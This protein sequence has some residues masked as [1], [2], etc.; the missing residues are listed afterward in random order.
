MLTEETQAEIRRL[1]AVEKLSKRAIGKRLGVHRNTVT[2]ALA[3]PLLAHHAPSPRPGRPNLQGRRSTERARGALPSTVLSDPAPLI[4]RERELEVLRTHLLSE[5]MRL[6]TL[7]GAGGIGKTRLAVAT[8]RCVE[9]S[10]PDGVWFV[11]LAPLNDPT[12]IDEAIKEALKLDPVPDRSPA[13]RVAGY[14]K[15]RSLLLILDNFEHLLPAAGRVSELLA[16]SPGLKVLVTSR[17]PL[18]LRLEHRLPLT[19][20]ALPDLRATDP[21]SV[22]QAPAAAL[23]LEHARRLQPELAL[24]AADARALAELLHRLDG[25]PLAIRIAA[26][27]S[28]VLSPDAILSRL[29]SRTLLSAEDAR[30]VPGRHHTLRD[31]IEWSY[32]LLSSGERAAFRHLGVFVGGWTLAAAE[33]VVPAGDP[34]S[35]VWATLT[36]VVDKSLAQVDAV[37]T[38]ERRYRM[39]E[40]IRDYA[41]EQLR[42]YEELEAARDRHARY[43]VAVAEQ[44]EAASF[45]PQDAMWFRRAAGD[46]DNFR[47]ALRWAVEQRDGSL[48]LRLAGSLA[49]FWAW[50]GSVR[51]GLRWLGAAR[52][53]AGDTPPLIRAKALTA[54]ASLAMFLEDDP[55]GRTL[56]RDA[57]ALAETIG[58]PTLTAR[59]LGRFGALAAREGDAREARALLE[60]SVAA[61][62]E[63]EDRREAAIAVIGLGRCFL[64]LDDPEQAE[65]AFNQGVD[66]GRR[67]GSTMIMELALTELARFK[68]IRHDYVAAGALALEAL[69]VARAGESRRGITVAA[70]IAAQVSGHR[71][72]VERAARLLAA[73]DA[74]SDWGQVLSRY[75]DAA[76]E[77]ALHV[78]AREQMGDAVYPAAMAEA[79][80][81]SVEQIAGMAQACLERQTA[82][83]QDGAASR[84]L[85]SDRERAVLRLIGEGLPNKQIATALSIAERTVKTHVASAMNKLGVDNRAHAAVV[86]IQRGLL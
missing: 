67:Q 2:R 15:D 36:L 5:S 84:P 6:V 23:F 13:E 47:A 7:T 1:H 4:G 31:A 48:S 81:M 17:E 27:H 19:G 74:W 78:R 58:D 57:L 63:A 86:A 24:T 51:E 37:T 72:D 61:Y 18:N 38:D 28:N 60:R 12:Q 8:G 62:E 42:R 53:L 43:Y 66:L 40:P 41:L 68:L 50:R 76:A 55:R 14:L 79:Q 26:A 59:V 46:H 71:G 21:K 54:E 69:Q 34:A 25:I 29:D 56:F 52:A 9:S 20:L 39:L 32:S 65:A 45:G 49:I 70:V 10:F 22:L 3:G 44:V 77:A 33:A 85:L 11:D 64:L 16:A 80:T 30:D 83:G 82:R 75:H 73:V 35:P